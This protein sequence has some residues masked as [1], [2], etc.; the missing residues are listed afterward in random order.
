MLPISSRIRK[1]LSFTLQLAFFATFGECVCRSAESKVSRPDKVSEDNTALEYRNKVGSFFER[2]CYDCHDDETK[3]GGLDL[4]AVT[5]DFNGSEQV[6]QWTDILN[7][8]ESGEMP[9]KNKARP[10]TEEISEMLSWLSPRLHQGDRKLREVIQ[11]RLNRIEYE[12]TMHDLL[13]IDIP[14]KHLLPEDQELHGFDNNGAALAISSEHMMRYLDAARKAID[15]AIVLRPRPE[16]KTWTVSSHREIERYLKSGQYGYESERVIAYLSNKSQ[17]S[18]ISTRDGRLPER[19]RYRFSWEAVT[20]KSNKPLV[21]SVNTSDF[22]RTSATFSTLEFYE[23]PLKPK[24]FEFEAV[25]G[26]NYAIQFFIHGLPTWI[27]GPAKGNFPGVAFGPVTITGPLNDVWPPASHTKLLGEV[28]LE[29]ADISEAQEILARFLSRTFRRPAKPNEIKRYSTMVQDYISQGRSFEAS[30]RVALVAA[31]CS[32]NFLYL[33]ETQ[34]PKSQK[35]NAY[36]LANRLSYF[37]WSSMPDE[38]LIRCA[39]NQTLLQTAGLGQQVERMLDDPRSKQFIQNFVGQWLRLREINE[40]TPDRKLYSEYDELLQHSLLQESELFFQYLLDKNLSVIN[41]LDSNFTIINERVAR[42]YDI[43]GVEGV[44]MRKVSLKPDSVR[45]GVLTQGALLKV[46][47]NG[48][49]TSPVLRGVWTLENIL[50]KTPRPPPPEIEGIE[51]DIRSAVTIRE[52][53]EKHRDVE[54]CNACHRYI[55]PPGFA[56]E[57]FDPVGKYRENY[58]RFVVNPEHADKGW[59]KVRDGAKVDAS[60]QL[61]TGETFSGI[62]DFKALLLV[63]KDLFTKCLTEKILT[64]ALG[65]ELGFSDRPTVDAIKSATIAKGYGLRTLIHQVIGSKAFQQN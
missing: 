54:S 16:V 20:V 4:F 2:H 29:T 35:L 48:T 59:G 61:V 24:R 44:A 50:G 53:L 63:E 6:L 60:G 23:A 36:E 65:R 5:P 47:A 56:L 38:E 14:L 55:D 12:N 32:P 17:Y 34:Q 49:N 41:C 11:R 7:R 45:G 19:G 26:K 42:H 46:T 33:D 64:Y 51:P 13:D 8:V 52:Q 31:L 30:L 27:N 62:R 58:L 10:T 9:P 25:L 28:N 22:N 18:K 39:A 40:T 43:D 37:L 1:S 15:A 57:S 3:K 21:F